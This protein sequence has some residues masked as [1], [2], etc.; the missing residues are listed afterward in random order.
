[1]KLA[2]CIFKYFP[3]GG[4]QRDFMRILKACLQRGYEID[5]FVADWQG[6]VLPE[7]NLRV[8]S[9]MGR[10]NH[11]CMKNF[12]EQIKEQKKEHEYDLVVGFNKMAGLDVY[13]A[14]DICLKAK[15]QQEKKF[16]SKVLPRY[17]QYLKLEKDIFGLGSRTKILY[18]TPQ[19]K[20]EFI[21]CY[22][23]LPSR[24]Y[25][26]PAGIEKNILT[27][28]QGRNIRYQSRNSLS[29]EETQLVL[30]FAATKFHNKGLDRALKA[31]AFLNNKAVKLWVIGGDKK[32]KYL[33]LAEK[34]KVIDQVNFLGSK[35]NLLDYMLAADLLIHPARVESAGMVLLEAITAGLP[36]LTTEV[37]G[38]AFHI[39]QANA[40]EALN[41]PFKQ[42][43]FNKKLLQ[44]LDR[45][46]LKAWGANAVAYAKNTDLYSM[47]ETAAEIID[48]MVSLKN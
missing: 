2:F 28:N 29:V 19:Q 26:V 32:E 23:A 27:V 10:T 18:L 40:G 33:R 1:M 43:Q 36:I 41:M 24:F 12:A 21:E 5:V 11:A 14:G 34:L 39:L 35:N 45:K 38:Y 37:C 9:V 4:L 13:F 15:L 20:K 22:H 8:L 6:D 3:Y 31:L 16:L 48:S 47:G 7:I 25:L 17:K 30:L 46:Q 44:M 42:A